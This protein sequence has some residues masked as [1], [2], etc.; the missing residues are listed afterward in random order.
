MLSAKICTFA[1]VLLFSDNSKVEIPKGILECS[2]LANMTRHSYS[3]RYLH[4]RHLP[5]PN[6]GERC[7]FWDNLFGEYDEACQCVETQTLRIA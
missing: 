2:T 3:T 6:K 7:L 1:I 4:F 5:L